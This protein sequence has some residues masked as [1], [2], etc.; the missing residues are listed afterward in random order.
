MEDA[1]VAA[2]SA[3][4][5]ALRAEV[6]DL[7]RQLVTGSSDPGGGAAPPA[8][9]PRAPVG[10]RQA[11]RTG[12]AV[13]GAA[14][15]GAVLLDRQPAAAANGSNLILG[16]ANQSASAVTAFAVTGNSTQT[17][18]GVVDNSIA[19]D[20]YYRHPSVLAHAKGNGYNFDTGLLVVAEQVATGIIV[21]ATTG[22]G[23]DL[24]NNS[25][26]G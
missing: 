25:Q 15:A 21:D 9:D 14:V 1:E 2:L 26:S 19:A 18:F 24:S 13:A 4:L 5:A 6:A 22:G 17:G 23:A 11:L 7:R 16:S 3:E 12:V 10:R 8:P 20:A